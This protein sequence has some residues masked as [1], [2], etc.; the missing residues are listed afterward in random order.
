MRE[1]HDAALSSY[2]CENTDC[3]QME[4]EFDVTALGEALI[5]FTPLG[6][7][8]TGAPIMV[9]N[10]GG[11]PANFLCTL[12]KY[13]CR[14]AFIGKVGDDAFGHMLADTLRENGVLTK[15]LIFDKE[16]FTTLAFVTIDKNGE[17]SFS[18]SR[19]PGA[20][21]KLTESDVRYD[22]V[23]AS[24]AFH[25]GTLS[26]T[27]EPAKTATE[28]AVD[29]A[30]SCGC[31]I[32]CD[33]NLRLPL[34]RCPDDAKAAMEWAIT[35]ADIVKISIDEVEFL[36]GVKTPRDAAEKLLYQYGVSLAMVTLGR[37]GAFI[38][39]KNAGVSV[40]A[41]PVKA[42]DTTGAG[43]IFGGAAVSRILKTGK[44]PGELS[45]NELMGIATFAVT[46][47]SLSTQRAGG[48]PSIPTEEEVK[49][50]AL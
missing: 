28:K 8:D 43:D 31:L 1:N 19:K 10:P 13:G 4:R 38:M 40:P 33:P 21:T 16:T 22:I 42:V 39:N 12:A 6:R 29:Y 48:I 36:W 45:H 32:T 27:D 26:L 49:G 25:I 34:W 30:K 17:R 35:V 44:H 41:P 46:A 50:R 11:A 37:D 9:A 20:D 5:D 3:G 47:A 14:T 7:T 15:G 18:F 2:G 24:R 23:A